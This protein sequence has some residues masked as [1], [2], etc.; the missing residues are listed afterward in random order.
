MILRD[1]PLNQ[2]FIFDNQLIP[3]I[4]NYCDRCKTKNV[5]RIKMKADGRLGK[6]R[7]K[8]YIC[9]YVDFLI[10]DDY[11]VIPIKSILI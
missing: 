8:C 6:V 5:V 3:N 4:P 1:L 7:I 11:H 2:F 10:Y 9:S